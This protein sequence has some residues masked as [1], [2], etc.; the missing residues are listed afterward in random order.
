M[1]IAFL[2]LPPLTL[3]N[4]FFLSKMLTRTPKAHALM[5]K[6]QKALTR[7]NQTLFCKKRELKEENQH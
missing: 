5:I 6:N 3:T 2:P 1:L 7:K 4:P